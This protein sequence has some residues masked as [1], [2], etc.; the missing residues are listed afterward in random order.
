MS[1]KVQV[2]RSTLGK[3]RQ[4]DQGFKGIPDYIRKK[5]PAWAVYDSVSNN[6]NTAITTAIKVQ[7]H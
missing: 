2:C 6:S 3:W 1:V 4:E 5:R 7:P